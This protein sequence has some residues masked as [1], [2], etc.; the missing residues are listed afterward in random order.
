MDSRMKKSEHLNNKIVK[1]S[2]E[3]IA[4]VAEQFREAQARLNEYFK[5]IVEQYQILTESLRPHID[6]WQKWVEKNKPVFEFLK[7]L[8]EVCNITKQSVVRVLRKYKWF[9]IWSLPA[10]F[11]YE[12]MQLDK[13]KG[14]HDKAVNKLFVDHFSSNNWQN[15][16]EMVRGWE[17]NPLFK[18]RM[19][20]LI[21]CVKTL[22]QI[23]GKKINEANV[24]LP[25]LIAQIDGVFMDYLEPKGVTRNASYEVKKSNFRKYKTAVL[26]SQLDDLVDNFLLNILYHGTWKQGKPLKTPF[27]FNRHKIIH[28]ENVRYG[29]I[30]YVVRA[31]MILD[32]LA[33]LKE[34]INC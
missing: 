16:E 18:K 9:F 13:K 25:T 4:K 26:S 14:R 31:F 1:E 6:F 34:N 33:H 28:G 20:I 27:G 7:A 21:D 19:N 32:R 30:D 12:I 15:L 23:K 3:G 17:N 2:I 22:R 11:V 29:R 24:V 5:P 8:P 10:S